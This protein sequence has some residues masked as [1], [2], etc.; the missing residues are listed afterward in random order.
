MYEAWTQ[1]HSHIATTA[2]I[3]LKS[4]PSDPTV[5]GIEFQNQCQQAEWRLGF[6]PIPL[7]DLCPVCFAGPETERGFVCIDGNF[8]LRTVARSAKTLSHR[9]TRDQRLF[10]NDDPFSSPEMPSDA[11]VSVIMEVLAD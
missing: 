2:E 9:D 4:C 10:V 7:R 11:A 5:T 1:I 3:V 6:S 8:Q